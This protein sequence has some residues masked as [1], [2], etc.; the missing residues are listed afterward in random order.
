M[1]NAESVEVYSVKS[2]TAVLLNLTDMMRIVIKERIIYPT[3]K[4]N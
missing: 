2:A 4:E 1:N 3:T